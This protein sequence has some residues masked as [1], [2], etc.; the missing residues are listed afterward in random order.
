MTAVTLDLCKILIYGVPAMVT[1][2]FRISLG[3]TITHIVV[4]FLVCHNASLAYI[5]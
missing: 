1:A 5:P 2:I 3:R 4:T